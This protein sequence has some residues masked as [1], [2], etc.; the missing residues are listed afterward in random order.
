MDFDSNFNDICT[1]WSTNNKSLL[2]QART[3]AP[4][5]R[6]AIICSNGDMISVTHIDVI[7][8]EIVIYNTETWGRRR[9]YNPSITESRESSRCHLCSCSTEGC[10]NYNLLCHQWIEQLIS[11]SR[12]SGSTLRLI[13]FIIG[14][15]RHQNTTK[16]LAKYKYRPR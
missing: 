2:F 16:C 11:L 4:N 6:Q 15:R 3:L 10:H 13:L 14:Q 12:F 1:K 8:P 7:R 5:R 9:A